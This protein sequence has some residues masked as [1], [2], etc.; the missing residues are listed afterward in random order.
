M[1]QEVRRRSA[2]SR[3]EDQARVAEL[4]EEVSRALRMPVRCLED[5]L[6]REGFEEPE[7]ARLGLVK[8]RQ[9]TV[10]HPWIEASVDPE[11]GLARSRSGRAA[12]KESAPFER[13]RDRGSDRDDPAVA[14]PG[15]L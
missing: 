13:P 15:L 14:P 12:V 6:R 1:G 9:E 4:V 7:V 11:L 5:P 3:A 10:H 8:P 2:P